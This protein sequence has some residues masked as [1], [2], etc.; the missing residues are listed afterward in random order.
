MGETSETSRQQTLW[1]S[2]SITFLPV[3]VDGPTPL[4]LPVGPTT[5]LSAPPACPVNPS[6]KPGNRKP[7][8]TRAIS[9]QSSSSWSISADF[10]SALENRLRARLD[11]HGSPEYA[12]TWKRQAIGLGPPICALLAR[13]RKKIP[14]ANDWLGISPTAWASLLVSFFESGGS[15]QAT[16]QS[17]TANLARRTSDSGF[18]GWRSPDANERGGDY[19]DPLKALRRLESGH[20]IN[21]ADQA[22]LAG[23]VSPTA[24]DH[25]RGSLPP[26]P[27]DTG[28]PLSQQ[29]TLAGWPT[30]ASR[31]WK[32]EEATDEF[33]EQRWSEARG[34]PL[35]AVATLAGWATPCSQQANS[36][37]ENF[38]ARKQ[39]SV[40]K[41]GKSMGICLTDLNM[42]V[43]AWVLGQTLSSSPAPTEKRG[44]LNPAFSLWLMGFP[45]SWAKC[46]PFWKEWD[47]VQRKCAESYDNPEAF[48]QWLV[49]VALSS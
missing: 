39:K 28:V 32:S 7:K 31:D 33:N 13:A 10:Q 36:T 11:V 27:Q 2:P 29:V 19:A 21:L 48:W 43:Q 25:S 24:Q 35:S 46:A 1:D 45:A 8:P 44:A 12:L 42:Q 23:W 3:L 40:E 6:A 20:Q 22:V 38:L 41:T 37:P 16:T 18:T 4:S 26:R 14:W 17:M 15:S 47:L 49:E 34:K 5:G 30:S 9:G